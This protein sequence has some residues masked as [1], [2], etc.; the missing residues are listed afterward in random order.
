MKIVL[1]DIMPSILLTDNWL[2]ICNTYFQR[3]LY[4]TGSSIRLQKSNLAD[5]KTNPIKAVS[6][7]ILGS[8][9]CK[10]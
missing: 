2:E 4:K 8:L 10:R 6:L 1:K 9:Q 7:P 5:I 3:I